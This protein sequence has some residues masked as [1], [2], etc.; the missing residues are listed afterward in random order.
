MNLSNSSITSLQNNVN[1]TNQSMQNNK[2]NSD[3]I[4]SSIKQPSAWQNF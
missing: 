3:D 1:T 4:K 2:N